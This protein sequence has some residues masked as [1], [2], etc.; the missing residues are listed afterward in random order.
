M[1][2]E[3]LWWKFC[4]YDFLCVSAPGRDLW[5]G[6]IARVSLDPVTGVIVDQPWMLATTVAEFSGSRCHSWHNG[7]TV[8]ALTCYSLMSQR[9]RFRALYCDIMVLCYSHLGLCA[10]P[11]FPTTSWECH[12]HPLNSVDSL[13][14]TERKGKQGMTQI[15]RIA[16][17]DLEKVLF[18]WACDRCASWKLCCL[19]IME[20]LLFSDGLPP[21]IQLA[22]P[23]VY[24]C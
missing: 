22:L 17:L 16:V 12:F 13:W 5:G 3:L 1:K 2:T 4:L 18:V 7:W 20:W 21:V 6:S 23:L 19:Y 24:W 8:T 14:R 9:K 15:L 10:L 11:G